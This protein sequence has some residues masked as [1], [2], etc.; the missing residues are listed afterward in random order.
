VKYSN[1]R[2]L[3]YRR[4]FD[5]FA[6]V[7]KVYSNTKTSAEKNPPKVNIIIH[8]TREEK[9]VNPGSPRFYSVC[10]LL[11]CKSSAKMRQF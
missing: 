6:I 2:P 4:S 10:F 9:V 5:K 8:L 11:D 3:R 1:H 7:L